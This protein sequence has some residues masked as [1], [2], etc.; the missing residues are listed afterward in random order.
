MAVPELF[1]AYSV[2]LVSLLAGAAVVHNFYKPD[3]VSITLGHAVQLSWSML[4][5][6]DL[7]VVGVTAE[8]SR[9]ANRAHTRRSGH[10]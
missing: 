9:R 6:A 1:K 2:A 8:A 3:L 5:T 4:L 7:M 10:S